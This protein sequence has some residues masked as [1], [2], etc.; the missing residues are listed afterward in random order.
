MEPKTLTQR[1]CVKPLDVITLAIYFVGHQSPHW[2]ENV[3]QP[4]CDFAIGN[5]L[6]GST[7]WYKSGQ[8]PGS[9]LGEVSS[10]MEECRAET[11]ALYCTL[12]F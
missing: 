10:S 1:K 5:L 3:C 6:I 8:T 2:K 7:S 9:V 12:S 11:V 4:F